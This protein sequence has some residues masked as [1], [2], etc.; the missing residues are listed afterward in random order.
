MCLTIKHLTFLKS[1]RDDMLFRQLAVV[2]IAEYNSDAK[3]KKSNVLIDSETF[4]M[5]AKK[6]IPPDVNVLRG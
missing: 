3:R 2:M 5:I 6:D 4:E 1:R